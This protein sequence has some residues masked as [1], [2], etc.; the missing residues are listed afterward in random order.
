LIFGD[1][2]ESSTLHFK[3]Y[4]PGALMG[5]AFV[6]AYAAI[7]SKLITCVWNY[8]F[9]TASAATDSFLLAIGVKNFLAAVFGLLVFYVVP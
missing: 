5:V 4:A 6:V 1:S 3:F 7:A 8:L 2:V 9:L